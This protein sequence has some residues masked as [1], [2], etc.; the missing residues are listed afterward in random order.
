[1]KDIYFEEIWELVSSVID[2]LKHSDDECSAGIIAKFPEA[3]EVVKEFIMCD[4]DIHGV[5]LQHPEIDGYEDEYYIGVDIFDGEIS[6]SCYPLK[7]NDGYYDVCDDT[8][9]IFGDCN[10][11]VYKHCEADEIHAIYIGEECDCYN[12][13]ECCKCECHEEDEGD[14]TINIVCNLDV[15]EANK[16]LDEIEGRIFRINNA[17][18]KTNYIKRFLG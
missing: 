11:R 6:V 3:K 16:I 9:Y 15:K 2:K 7:D 18:D 17:F 14:F 1:M 12:C 4:A 8:I 13:D 5:E 10:S